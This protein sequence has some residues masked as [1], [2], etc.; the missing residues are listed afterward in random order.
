MEDRR[1]W[2]RL[3]HLC[4]CYTSFFSVQLLHKSWCMHAK[5]LQLCLTLCDTVN[6]SPPGSSV[7]GNLQVRTLECVA[8][9]SFW[10]IFL[11]QGLNPCLLCL[12]TLAAW[13]LGT[14]WEALL[15]IRQGTVSKYFIGLMDDCISMKL[16]FFLLF[17]F[18]AFYSLERFALKE[19]CI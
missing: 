16:F 2:Q 12:P 15:R 17:N 7:Y 14:T 5:L 3:L 13:F 1:G 11:T 4:G 19:L 8:M 18:V 10:G 6:C 9:L